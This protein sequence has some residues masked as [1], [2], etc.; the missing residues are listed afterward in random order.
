MP[1][2]KADQPVCGRLIS[3]DRMFGSAPVAAQMIAPFGR[4]Q[5]RRMIV[6]S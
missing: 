6:E 4:Q 3:A 2:D 5:A 1:A